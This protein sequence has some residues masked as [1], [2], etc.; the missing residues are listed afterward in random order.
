MTGVMGWMTRVL[1][2]ALLLCASAPALQHSHPNGN[3]PHDHHDGHHEG[4]GECY[5]HVHVTLFGIEFTLPVR[6]QDDD[7]DERGKPTYLVAAWP[8]IEIGQSCSHF[9]S[10]AE[11]ILDRGE[12]LQTLP[13]FRGK[14]V[15]AA[16]LCDTARHERS[17]VQLM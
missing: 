14:T 13:T 8:T 12:P 10:F 9:A 2:F 16:L 6:S 11:A 17:G 1:M 15:V 5:A 3:R 4:M 7:S